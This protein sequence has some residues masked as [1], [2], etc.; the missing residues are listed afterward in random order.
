MKKYLELIDGYKR[1]ALIA[2]FLVV[3]WLKASGAGD[4]STVVDF[5]MK[6]LDWKPEDLTVPPALITATIAGVY[7]I[8]DGIRKATRDARVNRA[9]AEQLATRRNG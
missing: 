6:V 7:T 4:Y 1:V 5:L 3:A 9:I 2:L 8:F